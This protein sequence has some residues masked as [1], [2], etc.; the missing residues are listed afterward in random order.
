MRNLFLMAENE[1][2]GEA[3]EAGRGLGDCKKKILEANLLEIK[4]PA[5]S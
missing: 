2:V 5:T 4:H 3:G 1:G